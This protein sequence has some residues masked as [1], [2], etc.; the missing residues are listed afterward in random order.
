MA[1]E[2]GL[3]RPGWARGRAPFV[4]VSARAIRYRLSDLDAFIESRPR[5]STVQG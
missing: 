1:T 2:R 4:R 3:A 5:V